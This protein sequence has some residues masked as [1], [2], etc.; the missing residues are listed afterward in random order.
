ML[1][2]NKILAAKEFKLLQEMLDPYQKA[3]KDGSW[4]LND[5]ERVK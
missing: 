4:E 5:I 3:A 1:M 2:E